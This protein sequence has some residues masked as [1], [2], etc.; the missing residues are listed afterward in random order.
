M[1]EQVAESVPEAHPAESVGSR[2][3]AAREAAG[4][5][6]RQVSDQ[7]KLA[8]RQIELIEGDHFDALPGA[9]FARGFVRNYA[10]LLG[11]DQE[12]IVA[13]LD[14]LMPKA[15]EHTALLAERVEPVEYVDHNRP[16]FELE[17]DSRM[18]AIIGGVLAF[19]AV[20]GGFWWYIQKPAAPTLDV[21]GR[22]PVVASVPV[23][24]LSTEATAVESTVAD[25]AS[26]AASGA[27]LA[28][29]S[30]VLPAKTAVAQP[31][32]AGQLRFTAQAEDTW[33]QVFDAD[34]GRV[35]SELIPAGESRT[36]SG[37]RPFKI[38][39]GN[40]KQTRLYD[41]NTEVNLAQHTKVRVADFTLQ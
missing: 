24:V 36:V 10:R 35:L 18:T 14:R 6:V 1:T 22:E 19:A 41:G 13:D 2:L 3:K 32:P 17:L 15:S 30:A 12:P 11:L 39:V 25:V 38:K 7:L 37:K 16:A 34:G 5:T 21:D 23:T 8:P 31:A 33:V 20:V 29:A 28:S 27:V 4:L 9:T 26:A 40:A